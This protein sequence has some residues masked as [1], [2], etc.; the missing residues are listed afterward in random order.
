[1]FG[2]VRVPPGILPWLMTDL[3]QRDPHSW[4]CCSAMVASAGACRSH[5][6]PEA[7]GGQIIATSAA[8]AR[9]VLH[10]LRPFLSEAGRTRNALATSAPGAYRLAMDPAAVVREIAEILGGTAER[11]AKAARAAA[12]IRR[13]GGY[14]WVGIYDVADQRVVNLAWSGP[15]APAYPV[16]PVTQGLTSTAITTRATVLVGDVTADQRYLE[17]LGDTQSEIIVPVVDPRDRRVIGTLD[18][19]SERRAAFGPA[20]QQALE[21]AAAAL[22]PLWTM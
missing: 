21:R 13:A 20:D 19:E 7:C 14:R 1:M 2:V 8:G 4:A 16:F 22:L 15:A 10:G 12:V 11:A 5:C 3:E 17:A 18:V 6:L 9:A